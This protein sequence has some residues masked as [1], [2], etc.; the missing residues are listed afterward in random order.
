MD[1]SLRVPVW[2]PLCHDIM[3]GTKSNI[4]YYNYG[5]CV[6]CFIQFIEGR[7]MRWK[8]GWRPTK[9]EVDKYIEAS[10]SVES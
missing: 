1:E 10:E 8:S 2:C 6:N 3:K 5:C 7:E 4:T 9:E